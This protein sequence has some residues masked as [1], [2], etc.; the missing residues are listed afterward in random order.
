MSREVAASGT[1]TLVADS[2]LSRLRRL[3]ACVM[4]LAV[5]AP[6]FAGHGSNPTLLDDPSPY[7]QLHAADPVHWRR[8]DASSMEEARRSGR[9]VFISVGYFSCYWCHVMRRESFSDGSIADMLN[10]AFVPVKVDRELEPAL[11]EYLNAFVQATRGYSGWPLNVFLTPEGHPLL[12][13]VYLPPEQFRTLLQRLTVAWQR[14]RDELEKAAADAAGA[15]QSG[16]QEGR[17]MTV[18]RASVAPILETFVQQSNGIADEL[19][20]G[21]GDTSKFPNVPQLRTLLLVQ[22]L[23]QE[24][25]LTEFLML[26]LRQMAD[27]GLRDHLSGG[28]FRYT[29]DP[30]WMTPHF[31]KM[32]YD[33]AL[34]ADLYLQA[35][36]VLHMP[37]LALV[38]Y[39]T[40]DFML[41]ELWR[42]GAFDSSLSSVDDEDVEGGYYLWDRETLERVLDDDE[43][44]VADLAWQLTGPP[45]FEQGYLPVAGA[46]GASI[47]EQLSIDG[48]TVDALI[49]SARDKLRAERRNRT[50]PRDSKQLTGWN[51]IAL[52]ALARAGARPDGARYLAA[53]RRLREVIASELWTGTGLLRARGASDAVGRGSLQ[54]Y[55]YV[56][57]GLLSLARTTHSADDY[58]LVR[59]ILVDAWQRFHTEHGWR[60]VGESL[61]PMLQ[62]SSAM[63][64]G[65][66]PSPSAT[67]LAATLET[68]AFLHDQELR[69]QAEAAMRRTGPILAEQP[70]FYAS[71]VAV[72]ARFAYGQVGS[73][74]GGEKP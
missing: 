69:G 68:A 63:S 8:W 13:S 42:D 17:E 34:L 52:A 18:D 70:F 72:L 56:A 25:G 33:N 49:V 5:H 15:L 16:E 45:P 29:T 39:E 43:R 27:R 3:L 4:L 6:A 14:G 35:A 50:L 67:I 31:E 11:D 44:R 65:P 9:L 10:T 48:E 20:G 1:E 40:L 58:E 7:L 30:N 55:A 22:S 59:R 38:A 24:P 66:I 12:G 57:E 74:E 28:F 26:T 64:D 54:D 53:A 71:H 36:D 51:G 21:F 61:I 46:D 32:L 73:S 41:A 19:E 23:A 37:S 60:R 2:Q 62:P 47:A